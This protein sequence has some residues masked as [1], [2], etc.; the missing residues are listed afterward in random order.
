MLCS[1]VI[2]LL[3]INRDN[4]IVALE[5]HQWD[6]PAEE[7]DPYD[8]NQAFME[9]FLPFSKHKVTTIQSFADISTTLAHLHD[10]KHPSS[11]PYYAN[12]S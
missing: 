5:V 11:D 8:A 4:R 3:G 9:M 12:Y 7:S 10:Y 1:G 2:E 6:R